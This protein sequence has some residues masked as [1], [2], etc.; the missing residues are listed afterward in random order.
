MA[1]HL[2]DE[3]EKVCS[4]VVILRKG[5][6][7]YSGR[8]D[9]MLASHGYFELKDERMESLKKFLENHPKFGSTTFENGLL[10]AYL[11]EEMDAAELNT[12]LFAQDITLCHLVKRKESLEKQFLTLTKNQTY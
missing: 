11:N 6:K 3:V 7:L 8:V 5:E 1:S 4:H 10:T 12:L 9:G 2:L